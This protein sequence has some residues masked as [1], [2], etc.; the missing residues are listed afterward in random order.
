M[1]EKTLKNKA[2]GPPKSSWEAPGTLQNQAW[3]CLAQHLAATRRTRAPK[4]P[5]RSAQE[6]A[7]SGQKAPKRDQ[8]TPKRRPRAAQILE[9]VAGRAP[10]RVSSTIFAGSSVQQAPG[11]IFRRSMAG[12]QNLRCVKTIEKPR[13]NY[14]F[15]T[16]GALLH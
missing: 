10:R 11:T 3:A 16:S 5:A 1:C 2:L 4:R 12:A 13:K 6:A 9:N 8:E 7:K 15:Y 14:G